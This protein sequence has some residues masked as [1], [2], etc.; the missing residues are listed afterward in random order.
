MP[1]PRL[2]DSALI[3]QLVVDALFGMTLRKQLDI[4]TFFWR[5]FG[6]D[7]NAV[8]VLNGWAL[9]QDRLWCIHGDILSPSYHSAAL[10]LSTPVS[11]RLGPKTPKAAES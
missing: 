10:W 9:N 1:P 11:L 3:A 8:D 6:H 5:P 2:W 7:W 4:R